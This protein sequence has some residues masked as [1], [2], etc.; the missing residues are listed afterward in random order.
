MKIPPEDPSMTDAEFA[1]NGK[2]V[3]RIDPLTGSGNLLSFLESVA[4]R[5]A[6]QEGASFSL[7]LIDL[8]NF[9]L[10]NK[11]RGHLL[12]DVVLR[13]VSIVMKDLQ[14]PVYR[15]G[16]DE[17]VA[18]LSEGNHAER[19]VIARELFERLNR[20]STQFSWSKPASVMLIH[21]QNEKL[22]IADLWIAISDALFDAK[23]YGDRGFLVNTYSHASAINNYQMRVI[24]MLTERLLSFAD[25]LDAT[26]QIAYL[27]HVTQ[28]PNSIAAERELKRAIQQSKRT[29]EAFSILFIDGDN[30]RFYND[31]SYSAGDDMLKRLAELLLTHLRPGDFIAR[32][33]VGDEFLVLLPATNKDDAYVAAERL[34][35][36]VELRS[37]SWE[38]P[39]TISLGISTYPVHGDTV[40]E[41]LLAVE[42]AAKHSKEN[43]KNQITVF[44]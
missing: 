21:F 25:R 42:K 13:W 32:W 9:M 44:A 16:G 3:E 14:A 26:H 17:V 35:S 33:R 40:E 8:N 27:D 22:E 39:I 43:G 6:S 38:I 10:F 19:E 11:E 15:I 28:L 7:L 12:G 18:I 20:E 31:I 41:L 36:E 23:I 34:R 5:L 37:K 24:N 1:L 4:A 29:E 30:L 2:H